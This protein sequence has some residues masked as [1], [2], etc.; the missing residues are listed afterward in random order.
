MPTD[1]LQLV[2]DGLLVA[3]SQGV[4]GAPDMAARCSERLSERGAEGDEELADQ[5]D[6]ALGVA[7]MPLLR[8]TP[9]DLEELS[10]VLEGDPMQ[11]GG[12]VNVR[13]GEVRPF[14][15]D[16]PGDPETDE[17]EHGDAEGPDR[18]DDMEAGW[19]RV[20]TL[21]S[22]PGFEDMEGYIARFDDPRTVDRFARAISGRGA[23]RRF[24]D[25]LA[26]MPGELDAWYRYSNDRQAGRAR[27][28]L[29]REG[30]R[31]MPTPLRGS[32]P[33]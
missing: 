20:D 5:L 16:E 23:F 1:F 9:L 18:V 12:R 15:T 33:V 29:V 26:E 30:Y 3:L 32:G 17:R 27:A 25:T 24:K 10:M 8:S 4:P 22:R 13:T 19:L 6:A 14:F 28:W 31:P 7:P 11:S 2:G 21:G